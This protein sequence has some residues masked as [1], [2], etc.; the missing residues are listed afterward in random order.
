[1]SEREDSIRAAP[2]GSD[3]RLHRPLAMKVGSAASLRIATILLL[4]GLAAFVK[5][6]DDT[7][8]VLLSA[9]R[10][11]METLNRLPRYVCTQTIE[12]SRYE[13]ERTPRG[14]SCEEVS[15]EL[16]R[17]GW[18]RR[19]SSSDRL[20]LD[21]AVSHL[22]AGIEREMYS[23]AGEDH[24]SDQ[25]LFYLVQDGSVSTGSFSSMLASIFGSNAASFSYLGERAAG[26]RSLSEFDFRVPREASHYSYIL[27]N[28]SNALVTMEYG[29][30]LL[31]DPKTSDLT[32][33]VVRTNH[34]PPESGAC[35]L[36]QTL[37]YSRVNLHGKELLLPAETRVSLIRA[38]GTVAENLI[39][40]SAC[41]E[42]QGE[43]A[44]QF[45]SSQKA[46]TASSDKPQP[47]ATLALPSGLPF[48][49]VFTQSIDTAVAAA[50]DSIRAKL[51]T[52]IRDRSS[53]VLIP[54][55]AV[56]TA[57][58]VSLRRFYG[59]SQSQTITGPG[60]RQQRPSL[61]VR[62]RLETVEVGGAS[63]P[64]QARFDAGVARSA[65]TS[66]G[67]SQ[68]IE[69]G[70]LDTFEDS[71]DGVFPFWDASPNF[72]ITSGLESIWLTLG[73]VQ[74]KLPPQ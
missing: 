48:K 16:N 49:L 22:D 58:I 41:R 13:P 4:L 62:V 66:G 60:T 12:R 46:D 27:R 57:R 30:R 23:W 39:R 8:N 70:N 25:N 63:Y 34:L 71:G 73:P 6:Q 7:N 52:A 33:L 74:S 61:V 72:V 11:V 21:V 20:R 19:L 36:T 44:I 67:L 43:S 51:K 55:S 37:D 32:Q 42:F 45:A 54:E 68:R 18:K 65:K 35:E 17:A 26:G 31:V 1:M 2:S 40:Y 28:G 56:I 64:L 3:R 50:G 10:T 9:R 15:V 5:A 47:V 59:Q 38:D 29:G 24:F 14:H 53:K 69:L